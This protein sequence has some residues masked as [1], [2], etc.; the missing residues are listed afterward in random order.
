MGPI[1]CLALG[2]A[3]FVAIALLHWPLVWVLLVLGGL[4]YGLAWSR[5]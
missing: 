5:L 3:C 1:A 4:G 2:A